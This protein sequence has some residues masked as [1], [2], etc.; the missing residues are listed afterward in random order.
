MAKQLQGRELIAVDCAA[1]I[2][3]SVWIHRCP[4]FRGATG[5]VSTVRP[6]KDITDVCEAISSLNRFLDCRHYLCCNVELYLG[7]GLAIL[8]QFFICTICK[9]CLIYCN[10]F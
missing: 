8:A 4:V 1:A 3:W 5:S 2:I 10:T 6:R 7:H 9:C